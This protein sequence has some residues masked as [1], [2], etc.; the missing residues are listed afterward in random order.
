[1]KRDRIILPVLLLAFFIII[2]IVTAEINFTPSETWKYPGVPE[3]YIPPEYFADSKPTTPLTES[4]MINI[5]IS[6]QTFERFTAKEQ[7]GILAIPLSYLDF[8]GNFANSS[9][10]PTWHYE[11]NLAQGEPVAL[12]R[13]SDAMY[14]RMLAMSDG[15]NLELPI[16]VYVHQYSNLTSLNAQIH[17]DGIYLNGT[18][19]AVEEPGTRISPTVPTGIITTPCIPQS[20]GTQPAPVPGVLCILA[21]GCIIVI[22]SN[23]KQRRE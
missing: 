20:S 7:P 13:M 11:K 2:P 9:S 16:S 8:S 19:T 1:M 12:I 21:I 14:V 22:T 15:K 5:V 10:S 4:E 17:P 23:R 6:G 3:H 18:T